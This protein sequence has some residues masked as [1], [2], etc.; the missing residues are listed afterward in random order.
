MNVGHEHTGNVTIVDTLPPKMFKDGWDGQGGA[1]LNQR[2]LA[3]VFDD[4]A[5]AELG[6]PE[7]GIDVI[8]RSGTIDTDGN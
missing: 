3:A 5:A 1:D 4:E 6:P 2:I 8:H 7:T